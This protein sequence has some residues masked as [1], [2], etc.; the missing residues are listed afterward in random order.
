MV[1][2]SVSVEDEE[3]GS[4]GQVLSFFSFLPSFFLSLQLVFASEQLMGRS[5]VKKGVSSRFLGN[6]FSRDLKLRW[7]WKWTLTHSVDI[8]FMPSDSDGGSSLL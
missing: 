1:C 4:V 7:N 2:R 8:S 6:N 3:E 5:L